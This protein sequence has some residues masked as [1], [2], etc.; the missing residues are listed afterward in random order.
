MGDMSMYMMSMYTKIT[1][2]G[3]EGT[4]A[5]DVDMSTLIDVST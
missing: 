3:A 2:L 1:T 5:L 4:K